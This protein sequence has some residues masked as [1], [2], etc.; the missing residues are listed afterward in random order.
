MTSTSRELLRT[1]ATLYAPTPFTQPPTMWSER[2]HADFLC[3]I[4]GA[5]CL[6]LAVDLGRITE[7]ERAELLSCLHAHTPPESSLVER[8]FPRVYKR[9]KDEGTPI[10]LE[11]MR[12]YWRKHTGTE[13]SPAWTCVIENKASP[14]GNRWRV[15]R[16]HADGK[17][18]FA[19][20][21][22]TLPVT[23]D[24]RCTVHVMLD[25][26]GTVVDAVLCE[27]V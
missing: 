13:K 15:Y 7:E 9:F 23:P 21:N 3:T 2:T 20:C 25:A 27:L 22:H 26:N 12:A 18:F 11:T 4:Y 10:T 5:L 24:A 14:N 8:A 16:E 17:S 1:H 19:T 6:Q